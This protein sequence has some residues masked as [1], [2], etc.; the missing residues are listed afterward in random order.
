MFV[1]AQKIKKS[2]TTITLEEQMFAMRIGFEEM[3]M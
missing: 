1:F 3:F 2:S